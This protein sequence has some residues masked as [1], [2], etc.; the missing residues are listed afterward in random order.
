VTTERLAILDLETTGADPRVDRVAEIGLLLMDDEVVAEEWSCLVNPGRDIPP[1]I[2]SLTGISDRMVGGAPAFEDLASDLAQRLHGRVLV[3]H[4]ARFD[5]AFLRNEFRRA[6]LPFEAPVLCTV[7]LS[8][9]LIP[10]ER[11]HNLDTLIE[12]HALPSD[13]RHRALPD[14][15]LV[16]R[17]LR[18]LNEAVGRDVLTQAAGDVI[19]QP[20]APGALPAVLDDLPDTPGIYL[21]YDTD[22]APLYAG[23]AANLRT[24]VLAHHAE[25]GTR[26]NAQR[27]ALQAGAIE[28]TATA[29]ELGAALRHLNLVRERAPR[30]NRASRVDAGAWALHW[31]PQ[32]N[33]QVEAVDLDAPDRRAGADLYGPFRSR[34]DA[35]AALRG[36]AREYQLCASLLGLGDAPCPAGSCRGA[37]SGRETRAAHMLRLIQALSRLRIAPW[38]FSGPVALVEEDYARTRAELHVVRDWRYVGSTPSP[39]D[40]PALMAE[41]RCAR[42]FDVDAYRLVRR[43]L[44]EP[45]RFRTIDLTR[46]RTEDV[47]WAY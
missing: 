7:R 28:W 38:P 4:N 19:A 12:R 11:R 35:L 13:G 32:G 34:R 24:Q 31:L 21:L 42:A 10:A 1:D 30:Q 37:C 15:R 45:R 3:A 18:A 41:S 14:A 47:E 6:G 39:A 46:A 25:R 23:K 20:I 40:L 27:A 22:G 26:G 5:Y 2:E 9:A 36:I 8:R 17:L 29:G 44:D 43:A 16:L 33:T